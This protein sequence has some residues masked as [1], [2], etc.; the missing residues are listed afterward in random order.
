MTQMASRLRAL[1]SLL[2]IMSAMPLVD[3]TWRALTQ[4]LGAHPEEVW[5]RGTGTWCLVLLLA[6]LGVTPVRRILDWPELIRVR[7][8]LGLW[9]FTYACVHLLSFLALEHAMDVAALAA[10]AMKRP[11][12]AA[13]LSAIGLMLPLALTSNRWSMHKLG[14][15][16]KRLHRLAYGAAVLACLHF[17]LHRVAKANIADPAIASAVLAFLVAMRFVRIKAA[18]HPVSKSPE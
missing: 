14:G 5:L 15:H 12:V 7:R 18:T 3:L 2:W 10:D 13:G 9:S 16:W 1:K 6:T 8:M 11:F 17:F 4:S